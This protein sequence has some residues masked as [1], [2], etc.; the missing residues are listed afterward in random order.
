M[1]SRS[2]FILLI[3]LCAV[4]TIAIALPDKVEET[5][6]RGLRI[7][8]DP[9]SADVFI[10]DIRRGKTPLQIVGL[11]PGAHSLE[12]QKDGY[13]T[14]QEMILLKDTGKLTLFLKLRENTGR[15]EV[16]PRPAGERGEEPPFEPMV[17]V[18]GVRKQPG[19][20]VVPAGL[21]S[22]LVR[23]FGWRDEVRSV[24][25]QTDAYVKLDIE[26]LPTDFAVSAFKAG[27]RRFN[28]MDGGK[29][30]ST[31]LSF[32][33]SAPGSGSL[34]ITAKDGNEVSA[35]ELEPFTTWD[36]S[37]S[38]DGRDTAGAPLPDGDYT[39]TLRAVSAPS[40]GKQSAIEIKRLTIS[41]DSSVAVRP[42]AIAS[43]TAGA[44]YAPQARLL[45]ER[46][47]Q[48]EGSI[49]FGESYDGAASDAPPFALGLRFVPVEK[50][51]A[52]AA[53][54]IIGASSEDSV[55]TFAAS[56]RRSLLSANGLS[57]FS[58]ALALRYAWMSDD[59]TAPPFATASG[60]QLDF[61][62][63]WGQANDRGFFLGISPGLLWD[64]NLPDSALPFAILAAAAGR[65]SS[66]YVAAISAKT[67]RDFEGDDSWPLFLGAECRF[68]PPP[69]TLVYGLIAGLRAETGEPG[70]FGGLSLGILF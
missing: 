29:L 44:L 50:W 3:F 28:P 49:L 26:L 6:G 13:R 32:L 59:A 15:I 48:I 5:E 33:V 18:N 27:R 53:V 63:E 11:R 39:V 60:F 23:S 54:N 57:P 1:R 22:V 4:S 68:F 40:A 46:S 41:L 37:L 25:V 21:H 2:P 42:A 70:F 35:R 61:P 45:P 10:D 24:R 30:G 34:R 17:F 9:S 14:R 55:S 62:V 31:E 12:I 20:L 43:S 58:A 67:V 65:R 47:F 36:Q 8:T 7:E 66:T 19:I 56:I 16:L 69:S 38:W 51:E 52:G 64:G